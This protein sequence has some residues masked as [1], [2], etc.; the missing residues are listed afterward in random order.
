MDPQDAGPAGFDFKAS[1]KPSRPKGL[2]GFL[3]LDR[4]I[5]RP[6]ASLIVRAVL[7][8]SIRPNHLTVAAF[9]ISAAGAAAFLGGTHR[10]FILAAVLLYAGTV[11][12]GADGMLART[13][14]LC[15][16]FGA[17]LDLFLDR[18]TDFLVLGGMVTG[19]YFQ[20]GRRGFYILS[21]FGLAAYMLQIV[22]YYIEREYRGLRAGGGAS[23]DVRGLVYLGIFFFALIDRLDLVISILLCVPVLAVPY[24]L[25]RLWTSNRQADPPPRSPGVP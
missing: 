6:L 2:P 13:K 20:S 17:Y 16:R 25:V 22:L 5:N 15:T 14:N 4:L 21:L 10:S 1:L 12:D 19:Y 24:N 3:Q 7:G 8:T 11:L 18:I 9:V 23:G